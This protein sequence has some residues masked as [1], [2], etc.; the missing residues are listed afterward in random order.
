MD[1]KDSELALNYLV[2]AGVVAYQRAIA[3]AVGDALAGLFFSQLW[4]WAGRQPDDRDGWLVEHP[5]LR[6]CMV[7]Q[8]MVEHPTPS[9]VSPT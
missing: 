3:H 7:E 1:R 8:C 4:Y 2:S 6:Q 9:R 5:A